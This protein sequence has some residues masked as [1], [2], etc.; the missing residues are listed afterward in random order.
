MTELLSK[1]RSIAAESGL[2]G[3]DVE[4]LLELARDAHGLERNAA[5]AMIAS[6]VGISLDEAN[7]CILALYGARFV[8]EQPGDPPRIM[9]DFERFGLN[10]ADC[11]VI[12]RRRAPFENYGQP[13]SDQA[14]RSLQALFD[15]SQGP[16]Y[17]ALEVTDPEV[18]PRLEPRAISG[19]RTIFLM[20]RKTHVQDYRKLHYKE[21]TARWVRTLKEGPAAMRSNVELRVTEKPFP[22][23]Y[24]SAIAQEMARFDVYLSDSRSTRDGVIIQ[25]TPNTSLYNLIQARYEESLTM[26]C[27]LWRVWP[28]KAAWFWSKRLLLPA[29]L[30]VLG[31]ALVKYTNPYAA[32][33]S[34][35]A[36]GLLVNLISEKT[37]IG[38]WAKPTLF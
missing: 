36:L 24:T 15:Q 19:K 37:N 8:F 33:I 29:F 14:M 32:V 9:V 6:Q 22:D 12:R 10:A 11:E 4:V 13:H 17:L 1:M 25:V 23:L 16:I 21:I 34:T 2:S 28:L 26:S 7:Q 38:K 20:P 30:L 18:F 27:P 35:I 31:I 3:K 5:T